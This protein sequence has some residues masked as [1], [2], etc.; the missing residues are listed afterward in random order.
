MQVSDTGEGSYTFPVLLQLCIAARA[1][2]AIPTRK[3]LKVFGKCLESS[4]V[5]FLRCISCSGIHRI[6]GISVLCFF[7]V[8]VK[9][10]LMLKSVSNEMGAST[11]LSV[12]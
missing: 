11:Y 4:G 7:L 12:Q 6:L 9:T 10:I 5:P 1:I 8:A 2:I 3:S